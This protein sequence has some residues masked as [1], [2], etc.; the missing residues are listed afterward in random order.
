MQKSDQCHAGPCTLNA[1]D[2]TSGF[3]SLYNNILLYV[4]EKYQY[5]DFFYE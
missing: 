1:P 4:K 3:Q 2:K 5:I